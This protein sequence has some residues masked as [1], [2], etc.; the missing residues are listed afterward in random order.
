[1][2]PGMQAPNSPMDP[3]EDSEPG[4]AMGTKESMPKPNPKVASMAKKPKKKKP[5]T[6]IDQLKALAAAMPKKPMGG[7]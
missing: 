2:L 3:S 6:S 7:Y 5:I 4:E 1:M